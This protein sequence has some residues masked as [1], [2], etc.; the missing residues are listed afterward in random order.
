MRG[1]QLP[2][3]EELKKFAKETEDR[4]RK[5]F[6]GRKTLA[7]FPDHLERGIQRVQHKTEMAILLA[8]YMEEKSIANV[9]NLAE[10]LFCEPDALEYLRFPAAFQTSSKKRDR[11][12]LI[13]LCGLT[14]DY[15]QRR[16]IPYP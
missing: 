7:R 5:L 6:A 14:Y 1:T 4:L 8:K 12:Y 11:D 2:S 15:A 9:K 3:V 16:Y 13:A 10:L